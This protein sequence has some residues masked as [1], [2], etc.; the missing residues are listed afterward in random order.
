MVLLMTQFIPAH[1]REYLHLSALCKSIYACVSVAYLLR[2]CDLEEI[3]CL[4]T[5]IR[6]FRVWK[7]LHKT[8]KKIGNNFPFFSP[9]LLIWVWELSW[10]PAAHAVPPF[11]CL[12]RHR[13]PAHRA[14]HAW[15]H[16]SSHA[17]QRSAVIYGQVLGPV[18][19]MQAARGWV[20][21]YDVISP[22]PGSTYWASLTRVS[23]WGV[24]TGSPRG[25]H[26]SST[27]VLQLQGI[28][29]CSP[30]Q[31]SSFREFCAALPPPPAL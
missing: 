19:F 10:F 21:S 26:Q 6:C 2:T 12:R 29:C 3:I 18:C 8:G 15:A 5:F 16:G 13:M 14:T 9:V 25:I 1:S 31:P 23:G 17:S 30:L 11:S 7:S 4:L 20:M 22:Q 27:L 24:R 28:L